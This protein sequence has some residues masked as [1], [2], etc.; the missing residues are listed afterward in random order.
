MKPLKLPVI[1]GIGLVMLAV[2]ASRQSYAVDLGFRY[3]EGRCLN[4][5]G[6]EGLNP[7]FFGPCADL[8]QMTLARAQLDDVDFSGSKFTDS[9][10]RHTTFR[11]A[12]LVGVDFQKTRMDGAD[13]SGARLT[14]ANFKHAQLSGARFAGASLS[15]NSFAGADMAG[16]DFSYVPCADCRFEQAN[17]RAARL[18]GVRFE[19]A[20]LD[21]ADLREANLTDAVLT[22]ASLIQSNL[23]RAVLRAANFTNADLVMASL[24]GANLAKARLTGARLQNAVYDA[25]TRLPFGDSEARTR[26]MVFRS[27]YEF[28]GVGRDLALSDL[29][30]WQV[31]HHSLYAETVGL[32]AV[33]AACQG[34]YIML[35]CRPVGGGALQLAAYGR[36]SSVFSRTGG[37]DHSLIDNGVQFY[38]S[39]N[40][41][42]GFA[43]AGLPVDR[44]SC[45]MAS[46]HPGERLCWHT[47]KGVLGAGYRCG[48]VDR[49]N[50]S[51]A[52]ERLVLSASR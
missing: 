2:A 49:L 22:G 23:D 27:R 12:I 41:G 15:E 31:C 45:D 36:R 38:F 32:D 39:E 46:S 14:K 34:E 29:Q 42:V 19:R 51:T 43:P 1:V 25:R 52:Y 7:S 10:L 21:H 35:A 6:V 3:Q 11:H 5:Q 50:D 17:L 40:H 26:A 13:L 37:D 24:L 48:E 18:V 16:M 44:N 20:R 47:Q 28:S 33:M 8:R 30:G 9:D 4:A